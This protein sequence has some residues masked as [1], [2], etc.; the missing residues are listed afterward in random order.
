MQFALDNIEIYQATGA[1]TASLEASL[2][3][4]R[5]KSGELDQ[6]SDDE[7][8]ELINTKIQKKI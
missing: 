7:L 4:M 5:E 1:I 3:K 2:R 6:L 8:I